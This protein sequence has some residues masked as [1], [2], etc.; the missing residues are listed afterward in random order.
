PVKEP[1]RSVV[2]NRHFGRIG[3]PNVALFVD[4]LEHLSGVAVSISNWTEGAARKNLNLTVHTSGSTAFDH[5]VSFAPI[6]TLSIKNYDGLCIP[7]PEVK[8]V[9]RY[10]E[11]VSFDIVHVSTPGPMGIMG[12]MIGEHLG[13]PV[14]GT[15]HTDFPRYSTLLTGTPEIEIAAWEFMRSFYGTMDRIAAP[16]EGTRRDLIANGFDG[17]RI[18]VVG[19][20]V[21]AET[22][23]P[24]FRDEELRR[25]WFPDRPKKL[26]YV[27]RVSE[28]KN[29]DCLAY[30]FQ[31]LIQNH[32]DVCLVVVGSGPYLEPLKTK[33]Q[34]F[35]AVFTGR[36]EGEELSRIYASCDLFVFPSETDTFGIV[37]LEAQASGLPVIVSGK[38]GAAA[39]VEPE[40]TGLIVPEMNP[41]S[42]RLTISGL[43]DA[44]GRI[45]S[46]K[47]AARTHAMKNTPQKSFETFWSFHR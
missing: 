7:V 3:E 26:L 27:G 18:S 6:G 2:P 14:Y 44:P 46:M 13:L 21:D 28:E 11:D 29:L 19:R 15:Y 22:F 9:L 1:G 37:L 45:E 41:E 43:L 32:E 10:M 35:P 40:M 42:L 38:G 16:S 31:Q 4:A 5:S 39:S 33:L 17:D 34:G 20:G 47:N 30:A 23:D 36:K 25:T 8:D 12:K 24:E